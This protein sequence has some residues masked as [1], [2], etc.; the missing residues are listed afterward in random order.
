MNEVAQSIHEVL[1]EAKALVSEMPW[2][3]TTL[4]STGG[5]PKIV[6]GNAWSHS[7]PQ[8]RLI[9]VLLWSGESIGSRGLVWNPTRTNPIITDPKIIRRPI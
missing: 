1:T 4:Q 8:E 7:Y 3:F 9:R 5:H 2:H 6:T